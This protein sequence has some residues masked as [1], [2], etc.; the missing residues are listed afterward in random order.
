MSSGL[1]LER[2]V[3]RKDSGDH[4]QK[5]WEFGANRDLFLPAAVKVTKQ[6]SPPPMH[7]PT[8]CLSIQTKPVF[9]RL[10]PTW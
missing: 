7:H 10:P 5:P 1:V 4:F 2:E 9:Q 3:D 6:E 8:G